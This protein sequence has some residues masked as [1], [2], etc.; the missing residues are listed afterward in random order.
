[1]QVGVVAVNAGEVQVAVLGA[2]LLGALGQREGGHLLGRL[3]IVQAPN[4]ERARRRLGADDERP[5]LEHL[6]LQA[7]A[8]R[9]AGVGHQGEVGAGLVTGRVLG[10]GD[11]RREQGESRGEGD[12]GAR[13][14]AE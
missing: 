5:A 8:R 1:V 7:G 4:G 3:G 10:A 12:G 2:Q 14:E 9:L 13:G 11:R 6:H